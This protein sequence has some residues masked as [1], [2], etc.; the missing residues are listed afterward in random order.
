MWN[1]WP[2]GNTV[3]SQIEFEP[4]FGTHLAVVSQSSEPSTQLL[5]AYP[6]YPNPLP[7]GLLK[8]KS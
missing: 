5:I 4:Q 8:E 6:N 2:N 7:R 3:P 1:P